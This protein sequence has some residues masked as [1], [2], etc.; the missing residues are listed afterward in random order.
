MNKEI[1]M[2]V[3]RCG[4]DGW[5]EDGTEKFYR[6]SRW[7]T[8][9]QNYNPNKRNS[10]WDYVTDENGYHPY[11]DKFNPENGLFLDFFKWNGRTYAIDQF[12]SLSNPFY[13]GILYR[14][15][16]E[17]GKDAFLSGVDMDGNLFNPIYIEFDE[18]CERVR[19]YVKA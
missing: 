15:E 5:H 16:D 14:Y 2:S 13:I 12:W 7:I 1:T 10:L 8:V 11:N 6:V 3:S 4:H 18:Y 19:V 9:K 17:N